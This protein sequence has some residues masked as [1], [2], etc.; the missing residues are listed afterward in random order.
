MTADR[1]S[2]HRAAADDK[3]ALRTL[4]RRRRREAVLASPEAIA[5]AAAAALPAL[6][7]PGHRLG[8]YWPI[9]HEPSLLSL[10]TQTS[11][12]PP[13]RLALPM[14]RGDQLLYG[15]WQPGEVLSPDAC[16]IPA[17][18]ENTTPL[19]PAELA[20]LLVPALAL[21]RHGVRLGS[22]GGWYD[23]LRVDP[24][25]RSVPALAVLPTACLT[26]LLPRDSWDVPFD[27][28]LDERGVHWLE[29]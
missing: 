29:S 18:E 20:L 11:G 8:L 13:Q 23:R 28:W 25:W 1:A 3:T 19:E 24:A 10:T 4:Y 17:P 14:V 16:G 22:G 7:G 2:E 5:A 27:G 9:G 21:D 12:E 26:E 15:P 6:V